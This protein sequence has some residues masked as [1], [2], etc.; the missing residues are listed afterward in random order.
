MGDRR[1]NT[2]IIGIS[3]LNGNHLANSRLTLFFG[4]DD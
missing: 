2:E 4:V 1:R 3:Y